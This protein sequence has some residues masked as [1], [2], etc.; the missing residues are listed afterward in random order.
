MTSTLS[1]KH[2]VKGLLRFGVRLPL[3][4]YRAHLGWLLGERFLRLTHIG[5][6]SGQ[7]RQTVLEVVDH[8]RATD[9]YIVTS[10][11]GEKSDWFQNILKTPQVV[12]DVGRRHLNVIA[13]PL[14]IDAATEWL[15]IYAQAHPRTFQSLAKF[16]TGEKLGATH[17]D[18]RRVTE[19]VPVV[20]F[21]PR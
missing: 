4:L 21:R 18:C 13:E 6:K 11:W 12:I 20:A 5:R 1:A 8:E 9:S 10:G 2:P 16:M 19:A 17:E 15:F 14:S 3:W 7:P